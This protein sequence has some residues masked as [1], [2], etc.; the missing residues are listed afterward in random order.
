LTVSKDGVIRRVGSKFYSNIIVDTKSNISE[1]EAKELIKKNLK[2]NDLEFSNASLMVFPKETVDGGYEYDL[3]YKISV[4]SKILNINEIWFISSLHSNVILRYNNVLSET[5]KI[6]GTVQGKIYPEYPEDT[7]IL[8]NLENLYVYIKDKDF[9]L[10]NPECS[11]LTC[12]DD[13]LGSSP[14]IT[15]SN[16]YYDTGYISNI[17]DLPPDQ[18]AEVYILSIL[19]GDRINVLNSIQTRANYIYD[20]NGH[21]SGSNENNP[22]FIEP[23]PEVNVYYHI[24]RAYNY[25]KNT[26]NYNG[27][28]YQQKATLNYQDCGNGAVACSFPPLLSTRCEIYFDR[29]YPNVPLSSDTII[30]EYVHCLEYEVYDGWIDNKFGWPWDK[31]TS[32][33]CA[34]QEGFSYYFP[35]SIKG[36]PYYG[37]YLVPNERPINRNQQYKDKNGEPHHDGEIIASTLWDIRQNIGSTKTDKLVL[38]AMQETPHPTTFSEFYTALTDVDE[39]LYNGADIDTIGRIF[40]DHGMHFRLYKND[41]TEGYVANGKTW[42]VPFLV[43]GKVKSIKVTLNQI[44]LDNSNLDLYLEAPNG[45]LY[46]G[47]AT[48][49]LSEQ[50][51][52]NTP[53]SIDQDYNEVWYVKVYGNYVPQNKFTNFKISTEWVQDTTTT[54]STSGGG[55]GGSGGSPGGINF[56]EANLNYLSTCDGDLQFTIKAKEANSTEETINITNATNQATDAFLTGLVIPNYNLWITMDA[57][58]GNGPLGL[59]GSVDRLDPTFRQTEVARVMLDADLKLKYDQFGNI[60]NQYRNDRVQNWINLIENS[61]YWSEIQASGFY[62]L[63]IGLMRTWISHSSIEAN[64]TGCNVEITNLTLNV[65]YVWD[66]IGLYP[67]LSNYNLRQVVIDDI[68]SRLA[69]W[70]NNDIGN[71]TAKVSNTTLWKVNNDKKYEE[72]RR[73][74]ASLALAQWYKKQNRQD[75]PFTYYINSNN[76]TGLNLNISFDKSYWEQQSWH[77]IYTQNNIPSFSGVLWSGD[78]YGG[79]VLSSS[80]PNITGIVTNETKE[81]MDNA[82]IKEYERNNNT[83]YYGG[84]IKPSSP[85]LEPL[86]LG[87]SSLTPSSA[88]IIN[89]TAVIENKGTQNALNARIYFYDE[90]I[91]STGFKAKYKLGETAINLTAGN[92]TLSSILWNSTNLGM[93]NVTV[94]VDYGNNI[95]ES[96]EQ[97]N[98][99]SKEINVVTPYP[100]IQIISPIH[101]DNFRIDDN[102]SFSAYASDLQ[103]AEIN[104][105]LIKWTSNQDGYLGNSSFIYR[106]LSAGDHIITAEFYDSDNYKASDTIILSV[107]PSQKPEA[108]IISPAN[109]AVFSEGELIYFEGEGIDL[110]DGYLNGSALLWNSSMGGLIGYGNLMNT[111]ELTLGNHT[112]KLVATDTSG[113]SDIKN[114]NI[115]IISGYPNVSLINPENNDRY[116]YNSNISFN[117]SGSDPQNKTVTYNWYSNLEGNLNNNKDFFKILKS[118][119]HNIIFSV[120]DNF[121]LVNRTSVNITVNEPLSPSVSIIQSRNNQIFIHTEVISFTSNNNDEDDG[122]K[123]IN[124]SSNINGYLSNRSSFSLNLSSLSVGVHEIILNVTDNYNLSNIAKINITIE[125]ATPSVTINVPN[126]SQAFKQNYGIIFNGSGFDFEDVN[127]SGN[128][129][130]WSSSIN[131]IIGYGNQINVSNLS[132]GT[133]IITLNGTDSNGK[134]SIKQIIVFVFEMD[135]IFLNALSDGSTVKNLTYSPG[136]KTVYVKIPKEANV[137]YASLTLRGYS[138]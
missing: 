20:Y 110:E 136:N 113:V 27:M 102:I 121:G 14:Y 31:C 3:T 30:H 101:G 104:E 109:N 36:N 7:P 12:N 22:T 82:T 86:V 77:Y 87:F 90:Y 46:Y 119:V 66:Y 61:P 133:H 35:S 116:Y 70:K 38:A 32:E 93:H 106:N 80:P 44:T 16:G 99:Y 135:S 71:H 111:N 50:I 57:I 47:T 122:I 88:D 17:E 54:G 103:D 51:S 118:G 10:D 49:Q 48:S 29:D 34:M 62:S 128:N 2:I 115:S 114:V 120:I 28:D 26:L 137:T 132:I 33:A 124:W 125:S 83:I 76:I 1:E 6:Y 130:K 56:T 73:V 37:S 96:N 129:L 53:S 45:S 126:N 112:I 52:L 97:N 138:A 23:N 59:T 58:P 25:F 41:F 13:D 24:N 79:V 9:E 85:D 98:K 74:A 91:Y 55:G 107:I 15:N 105:S 131:G 63:P 21:L 94:E 84:I 81:L 39:V 89:T 42:Q 40:N 92:I 75:L 4:V 95:K 100:S 8:Q 108:K 65:S 78:W 11:I 43:T 64:G 5:V 72:L 68:N 18:E 117:G 60:T 127:L 69:I 123:T 67:G 19:K 134:S